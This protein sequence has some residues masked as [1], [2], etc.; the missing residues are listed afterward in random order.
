MDIENFMD[1]ILKCE[2]FK[3]LTME[4]LYD[5]FM[6]ITYKMVCMDKD[7]LIH[8]RNETCDSIIIILDL[9]LNNF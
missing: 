2:I 4:K 6:S 5:L 9:L 8:K 1:V 7:I 3:H